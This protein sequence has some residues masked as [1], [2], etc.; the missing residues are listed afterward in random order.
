MIFVTVGTQ[1]PFDR[2]LKS[3]EKWAES[4]QGEEIIIQS[5]TSGFVSAHCKIRNH[6]LPEEWDE[7]L[8][9]SDLVISHAGM[10]TI[11]KCLDHE[12]PVIIMP[13]KFDLGEV[14]NNHQVATAEKL[15]GHSGI[16][17]VDSE[18]Q[19]FDAID[20]ILATGFSK[21]AN[22]SENIDNLITALNNFVVGQE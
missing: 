20:K 19:L 22:Q 13:R 8:G 14:R 15:K 17:V 2:L 6:I 10:G 18:K 7:L 21:K 12:K 11:L 3:V 4:H 5:G 1:L 16:F 9:N